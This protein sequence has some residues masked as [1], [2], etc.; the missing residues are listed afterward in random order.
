VYL[1]GL[2]AG[3]SVVARMGG[4]LGYQPTGDEA[5]QGGERS[6]AIQGLFLPGAELF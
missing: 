5:I 3:D 1:L 2:L 4:A 6:L